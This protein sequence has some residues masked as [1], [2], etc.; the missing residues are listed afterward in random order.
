MSCRR[1]TLSLPLSLLCY[2]LLFSESVLAAILAIDYG[3]E[4]TKASLV[5][6]GVPFDVLLD[7]DSKRK[8][9][10]TVAWKGDDRLFGADAFNIVSGH[11][12]SLVAAES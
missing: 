5:K 11:T 12:S 7:R 3:T 2:V 9:H 10:S 1:K 8:I 4:F 6:S